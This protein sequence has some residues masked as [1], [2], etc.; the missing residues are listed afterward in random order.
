MARPMTSPTGNPPVAAPSI[1]SPDMATSTPDCF[2]PEVAF[3][4]RSRA[5]L[6]RSVAVWS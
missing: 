3:S 1:G 2:S 5:A 6:S 4:R